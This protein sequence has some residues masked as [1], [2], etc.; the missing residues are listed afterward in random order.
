MLR[1][2]DFIETHDGL[3]FSAVS[4]SHPED[5][6]HAFLRYYPDVN[7]D[8][9]R[10]GERF[11]KVT[12]I[13][14]S[15]EFLEKNHPDH[16]FSSATGSKFQC[17][18]REKV[19][20]VYHPDERLKEIL[21]RAKDELEEKVKKLSEAFVE[22]PTQKKGVT[23]SLL[24]DLH[25]PH[26]DIDFVI[27]GTKN[28][29]RARNRL[30]ELLREGAEFRPLN[31]G[32]WFAAYEKRFPR[33]KTL[34]FEEFLWHEMR[35]CHKGVV[36][37]TI[38]DVLLVRDFDEIGEENHEENFERLGRIKTHCKVVDSSLAFDSPSIYKVDCRDDDRIKEVVSYT[39]TYAGQAFEGEDIK[40]S[41]FLER[42]WGKA[43]RIVVGTTREARGEYIKVVI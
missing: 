23:G 27:Y 28:H 6:Y 37:N 32:E 3:I 16:I 17:V 18:P 25:N 38:F 33:Y 22:V 12:S 40:V 14:E 30:R 35:K 9:A 20:K 4:Y 26:S 15:F 11:K 43:Y 5:R 19:S 39:H 1:I 41:G 24:V 36:G 8:R 31:R 10:N 13:E 21:Y 7:G 2:R 29:E 34:S 42:V